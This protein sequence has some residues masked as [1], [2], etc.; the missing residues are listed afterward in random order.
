VP[1]LLLFWLILAGSSACY[2]QT[3]P[4]QNIALNK[5]PCDFITKAEA[6]SIV[7]ASLVVRRNT[8]DECWYV[9]SGF[10]DPAGP[11]NRQVFVN[12]WRSATPQR[13]DVSTTRANIA[14]RQ[15]TAVTR[16][17]P[18]FADAALWTWTPGAGRLDAFKGGTIGVDVMVGGIA[19]GPALQHAKVLAARALGGAGK[20]GYAYARPGTA[21]A[22]MPAQSP[23]S[24][25]FPRIIRAGVYVVRDQLRSVQRMRVRRGNI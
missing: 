23:A 7:G 10:T 2:A 5:K 22:P 15:R 3:S 14:A 25:V 4:P 11:R 20:T 19:E 6:E 17:V 13:D 18:G 24:Y 8:D 9:E 16:D 21:P 1:R 12:I